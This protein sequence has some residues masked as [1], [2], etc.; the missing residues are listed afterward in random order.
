MQT[1]DG[2]PDFPFSVEA[3]D[4]DARAGVLVTPRGVVRTPCF[5]PVGTKGTVKAM[6]PERLKAVGA[7]I[8]LANTYH[9]A[10]RPGS[11]VVRRLGGLHSFMQWDGP[12][13]HRQ[14]GVPGLQSAGHGEH[15]G[16]RR[17]LPL[18]L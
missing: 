7:Q 18:H 14:R 16:H 5:M 1:L 15:R 11:D 2:L 8:V 12:H 4:G 6:T 17:G 10:L 9:L 3:R 13:P